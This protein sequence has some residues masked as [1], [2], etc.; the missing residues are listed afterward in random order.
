VEKEAEEA[1]IEGM[2]LE[3]FDKH[4]ANKLSKAIKKLLVQ[5]GIG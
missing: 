4:R 5:A 3:E 2:D 1:H